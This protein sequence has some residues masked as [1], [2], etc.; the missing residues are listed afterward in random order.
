M[1]WKCG[2]ANFDS[3]KDPQMCCG[4]GLVRVSC[5]AKL[6]QTAA[7]EEFENSLLTRDSGKPYALRAFT[8]FSR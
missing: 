3:T 7:V 1:S 6:L 4:G 8:Y 2:S 5:L